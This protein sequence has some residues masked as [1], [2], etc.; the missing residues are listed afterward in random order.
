[1]TEWDIKFR[2]MLGDLVRAQIFG[3]PRI[4]SINLEK[5]SRLTVSRKAVLVC[6]MLAC[7]TT[8]IDMIDKDLF[9]A[10]LPVILFPPNLAGP[11]TFWYVCYSVGPLCTRIK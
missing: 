9:Q 6:T 5:K 10:G 3:R 4:K 2:V 8:M 7:C 11:S 1:M